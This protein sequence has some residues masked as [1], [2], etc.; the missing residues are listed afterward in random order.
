MHYTSQ[1]ISTAYLQLHRCNEQIL[2]H[3]PHR[4]DRPEGRIDYGI[5][6]LAEGS[7]YYIENGAAH[8]VPEKSLIL[9]FPGVPQH[10]Y[11]DGSQKCTLLWVHFAGTGCDT[12]LNKIKSKRTVLIP[13]HQHKDFELIFRKMIKYN[14]LKYSHAQ[15]VCTGFLQALLGMMLANAEKTIMDTRHQN[16]NQL[17]QVIEDMYTN[18]NQPITLEKYAAM[19]YVSTNR[20]IHIFKEYTGVSPYHYHLQIR[21]DCAIDM[22][23]NTTGSISQIAASVGYQDASYFCRIFKKITG[24]KP[25][26]YRK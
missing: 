24:R 7:A 17:D 21:M 8:C 19:C 14:L 25:S 3:V 22:L 10:Y 9:H 12:L 13:I 5:Q 1:Q 4:T 23:N 15:T 2:D 11:F 20:F 26:E 18:Y 16:S 6:Y